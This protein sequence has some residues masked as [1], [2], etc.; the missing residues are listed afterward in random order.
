MIEQLRQA[1]ADDLKPVGV[2]VHDAWPDR[3]VT[4]CIVLVPSGGNYVEAGSTF[5]EY[6]V[7]MDV[8]VLVAR[9]RYG[10]ALSRLDALVEAVLANTVDWALTGVE[11]PS[12]V[13]I[14]PSQVLGTV[15]ALAK[16]TRL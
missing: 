5:G 6:V 1:L 4:P 15:V 16:A 7:R 11:T 3:P 12:L 13:A 8:L 10:A 2:P 9:E 14:G